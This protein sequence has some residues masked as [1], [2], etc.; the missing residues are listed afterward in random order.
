MST[1]SSPNVQPAPTHS[2]DSNTL[3]TDNLQLSSSQSKPQ[4]RVVSG[5]G[6]SR[7]GTCEDAL[8]SEDAKAKAKREL[9]EKADNAEVEQVNGSVK[10]IAD[11]N[12]TLEGL[13]NEINA[14]FDRSSLS[15]TLSPGTSR[16][17]S[18]GATA[19]SIACSL[20]GP[21]KTP[22]GDKLQQTGA[23]PTS[24]SSAL[25]RPSSASKSAKDY[26]SQADG[27]GIAPYLPSGLGQA[28]TATSSPTPSLCGSKFTPLKRVKKGT[29]AVNNGQTAPVAQTHVKR[30]SITSG[31]TEVASNSPGPV[32]A[33]DYGIHGKKLATMFSNP[34]AGSSPS[35]GADGGE[36]SHDLVLLH[37][38]LIIP[39]NS[40]PAY[41]RHQRRMLRRKQLDDD[42]SVV[43]ASELGYSDIEETGDDDDDDSEPLEPGPLSVLSP[44]V[45]QRGILIPHPRG[46]YVLLQ[47]EVG[48]TLGLPFV[49]GDDGENVETDEN[50]G[51]KGKGWTMRVYARNGWLTK[52]AWERAWREMERVDVE[53]LET[54]REGAGRRKGTGRKAKAKQIRNKT[55]KI[56]LGS[57]R[58]GSHVREAYANPPGGA[59]GTVRT[60]TGTGDA[61]NAFLP[62]DIYSDPG[63]FID[64]D[65]GRNFH[66]DNE[67]TE[68]PHT[69]LYDDELGVGGDRRKDGNTPDV[70]D[71]DD[72]ETD[73][74]DPSSFF[75]QA[76]PSV[77][78]APLQLENG[79]VGDGELEE[80][81]RAHGE[82]VEDDLDEE[83]VD[84]EVPPSPTFSA[85]TSHSFRR[86]TSQKRN[87]SPNA[88]KG[89]AQQPRGKSTA[90][91]GTGK[92]Q[93]HPYQYILNVLKP[94]VLTGI[95]VTAAMFFF[96]P[97]HKKNGRIR[98][99]GW[100]GSRDYRHSN[101]IID[102]DR[103]DMD[104]DVEDH[105]AGYAREAEMW[106]SWQHA[107]GKDDGSS[108][109]MGRRGGNGDWTVTV[110]QTVTQ[111]IVNAGAT[112]I[113]V[114]IPSGE[115]QF[116]LG[117]LGL[118]DNDA[119]EIE[120]HPIET[121]T[122]ATST[123]PPAVPT[124]AGNEAEAG[125][126][127]S[128]GEDEAQA[129][130]GSDAKTEDTAGNE[131]PQNP[132]NSADSEE[133]V[134][135]EV[136]RSNWW[137]II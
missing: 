130:A 113:V 93:L 84:E 14:Q 108:S 128:T 123:L 77:Q 21:S 111:R 22:G 34:A 125:E 67:H 59:S 106:R 136:K 89:S 60:N 68:R 54:E 52:G 117:P 64:E 100:P 61:T 101:Q 19:T 55:S 57:S 105:C 133:V 26:W 31:T 99:G 102:D 8:D 58:G 38:S 10:Q 86:S 20:S 46:D 118:S 5:A 56:R 37:I 28:N 17:N 124:E 96:G 110:T 11:S 126:N 66:V 65:I 50:G 129:E 33:A 82:G 131:D 91:V 134:Y 76:S 40:S 48:K 13:L 53:I 32:D 83:N 109:N 15:P 4:S 70:S 87:I 45:Y 119:V 80:A 29:G 63:D 132:D 43:S 75:P 81:Y 95:V 36:G 90:T 78:R 107:H 41:A 94:V 2:R 112:Q 49:N 18:P 23:L 103:L 72:S 115:A 3:D 24:D 97:T 73:A 122:D 16:A 27:T 74:N 12:T 35:N 92:Q 98:Y 62:E 69:D 121:T 47:R 1:S 7:S 42:S 114:E 6:K 79:T 25:P 120:E 9:F 71:I 51:V 137:K 85:G 88:T 44:V 116:P 104:Q 127:G 135:E 30:P 39:P